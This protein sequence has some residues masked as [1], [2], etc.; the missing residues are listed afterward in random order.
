MRHIVQDHKLLVHRVCMVHGAVCM[1][2]LDLGYSF[3][4]Y[5]KV[6]MLQGL[7]YSPSRFSKTQN[8]NIVTGFSKKR[9]CND[10]L[11]KPT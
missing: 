6:I 2:H 5:L 11:I 1:M 9:L 8:G 4:V 7:K 10:S 3:L